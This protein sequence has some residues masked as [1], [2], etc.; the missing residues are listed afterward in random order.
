MRDDALAALAQT[1]PQNTAVLV[2]NPTS[3]GGRRIGLLEGAVSGGTRRRE[4][5]APVVTQTVEGGTLVEL[6]DLAPYSVDRA[7]RGGAASAASSGQLSVTQAN[8]QTVLENALIRVE[9]NAGGDL[10]RIYDKQAG[11]EVL[12]DGEVRQRAAGV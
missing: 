8:G 5:A 7:A 11:R 10:T 6:R 2:A 3:F 1:L 9:L 12:A 4:R